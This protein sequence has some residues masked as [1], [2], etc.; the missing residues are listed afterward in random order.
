LAEGE[1]GVGGDRR[2]GFGEGDGERAGGGGAGA[3]GD[4]EAEAVVVVAAV[5]AVRHFARVS[6]EVRRAGR[7]RGAQLERAV[8]GCGGDGV[9]Q[10]AGGI[11]GVG[12]GGQLGAG[13]GRSRAF[14]EG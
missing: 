8:G 5:V 6:L 7:G 2:R 12:S 11:S 14:A 3:V 9:D 13:D 1:P 4:G 10:L